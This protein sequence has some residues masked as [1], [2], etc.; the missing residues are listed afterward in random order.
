MGKEAGAARAGGPAGG[1]PTRVRAVA[2]ATARPPEPK[3]HGRAG[4]PRAKGAQVRHVEAQVGVRA[5]AVVV[6]GKVRPVVPRLGVAAG[7]RPRRGVTIDRR[8]GG[9]VPVVGDAGAAPL[10]VTRPAVL[11]RPQGRPRVGDLTGRAGGDAVASVDVPRRVEAEARPAVGTARAARPPG[12]PAPP[13]VVA[14]P[15]PVVVVAAGQAGAQAR[16]ARARAPT[17]GQDAGPAPLRGP[18]VGRLPVGGHVAGE[19]RPAGPAPHAPVPR[20]PREVAA[21]L[22][23]AAPTSG[24]HRAAAAGPVGTTRTAAEAPARDADATVAPAANDARGAAMPPVQTVGGA[25][26][27]APFEG[28]AAAGAATIHRAVAAGAAQAATG[29]QVVA[30]VVP[31]VAVAARVGDGPPVAPVP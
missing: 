22:P 30:G 4:A 10:P 28:A 9:A 15:R 25:A 3:A 20:P 27:R 17:G 19:A 13:L 14:E 16:Q 24:G 1:G 7:A 6:R 29:R 23:A 8:R 21:A 2:A 12:L 11:G 26:C 5:A 31:R 18:V